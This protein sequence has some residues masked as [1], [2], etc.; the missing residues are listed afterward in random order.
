MFSAIA[1]G[2]DGIALFRGDSR[3][4][5]P[6]FSNAHVLTSVFDVL[7]KMIAHSL[8]QGGPGF[9]YLAP[10]IYAYISTGNPQVASL[11]VLVLDINNQ[12]LSVFIEKVIIK[13][14]RL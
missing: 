13:I 8:I 5:V 14:K 2:K 7:G 11:K 10:V 9:P 1:E 3:G 4:K 6:I 12:P